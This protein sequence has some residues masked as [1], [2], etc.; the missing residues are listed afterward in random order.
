[1]VC[2]NCGAD[3]KPGV[4]YCLNCGNY[5]DDE[6]EAEKLNDIDGENE[7]EENIFDD[8]MK[9]E[10]DKS[11]D[12]KPI[13][14]KK[15]H[16][17][18]L[19]DILIYAVLV[20]III[21]SFIVIIVST[22]NSKKKVTEPESYQKAKTA[23]VVLKMDNYTIKFSGDLNYNKDGDT[24]YL[25]DTNEYTISYR[26]SADDYEKYSN[27]LTLLS[28]SLDKSG[29]DVVS[30]EKI[31][32]KTSE[33]IVYKFKMNGKIKRFYVTK[34]NDSYLTMG[35]VETTDNDN[36]KDALAVIQ[37][38]NDGIRFNSTDANDINSVLDSTTSDLSR[39]LN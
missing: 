36:W 30:S 23:D 31:N 32:I 8:S 6:D 1:M 24:V 9:F 22:I 27:D 35:T 14:K 18:A 10:D 38:I 37:K 19:K 26:N 7:S 20:S 29:Y 16:H 39:I 5:I 4:K 13:K 17:M 25:Y 34:I 11:I 28:N 21:I 3:L 2:K 12:D 15:R 33:F